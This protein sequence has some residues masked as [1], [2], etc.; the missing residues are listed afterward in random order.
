[1]D[2]RVKPRRDKDDR[3]DKGINGY[4]FSFRTISSG[5]QSLASSGRTL[6]HDGSS[7]A[8]FLVSP[9]ASLLGDGR[10]EVGQRFDALVTAVLD[11]TCPPSAYDQPTVD[12]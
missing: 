6:R 5:L 12:A 7:T 1:V 11:D 8:F 10:R 9:F 2:T 4:S 3:I